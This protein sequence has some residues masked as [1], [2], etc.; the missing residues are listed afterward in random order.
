M[1]I[2]HHI[3]LGPEHLAGNGALGRYVFLPGDRARAA[4][5]ASNF[6]GE[7]VVDN[8]RGHTAHLG[9]IDPGAGSPPIEVLS[10]SSGRGCPS[11]EIILHEL[12]ACGARRIV[13]VGS[14]GSLSEAVRAGDVVI[15]TGAVRDETTSDHYAPKEFPALAHPV[16]VEALSRGARRAGLDG[17]TFRGISHSKD[18]LYAREFGA[19]PAGARN[20]D[21]VDWLSRSGAIASEMEAS[22]LF[23]M[24]SAAAAS[25]PARLSEESG[26]AGCQAGAVLAVFGDTHSNM[27]LDES[28]LREAEGRAIQ[29]AIEGVKAWAEL[30]RA[31]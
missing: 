17:R 22:A 5:I 27:E 7:Q 12:I 21:Y 3:R 13:R 8:P 20:R 1:A 4:R 14:C 28:L 6:H 19:G 30:D 23:V 29:V 24:A 15:V 2:Q 31:R 18:S 10:I 25:T 26:A 16:A 11:V 9:T